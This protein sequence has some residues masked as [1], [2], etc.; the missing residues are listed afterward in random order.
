MC[1]SCSPM[2]TASALTLA[3]CVRFGI[4][5]P[6]ERGR[7][8][9]MLCLWR[10]VPYP[11]RVALV[12]EAVARHVDERGGL[13]AL[14]AIATKLRAF[15]GCGCLDRPKRFIEHLTNQRKGI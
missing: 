7:V 13:P 6:D 10:G 12:L 5:P 14:S 9:W 15:E 11:L 1:T 8:R 2:V 4:A 3:A